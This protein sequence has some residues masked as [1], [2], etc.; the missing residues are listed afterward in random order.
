L[1]FRSGVNW[2]R[3]KE[4]SMSDL[5]WWKEACAV[6]VLSAATAIV[7]DGQTFMT[8]TNFEGRDGYSPIGSLVQGPDGNFYG[9][10]Q[11]GGHNSNGCPNIGCGTAFRV[12]AGGVVTSLAFN[13]ADGLYPS[14][15]LVLATNGNFYG[16]APQGGADSPNC[17]GD[18]SCGSLFEVTPSGRITVLHDFCSEPGCTDGG[19]PGGQYGGEVSAPLTQVLGGNF[20]GTT[21]NYG[22]NGGGTVFTVTTSGTL[23]TLYSFC[24]LSNCA[25][26]SIPQGPPIQS[27]DGI[28]YG[29]TGSG[30]NP[31][32]GD[33]GCGTFYKITPDGNLTTLHRFDGTDGW[34]IGGLIQGPNG[35]FYGT[36]FVGGDLTCDPPYGCGTVFEVT[37]AGKVT[38]LHAFEAT[39]GVGPSGQLVLGSDGNFYGTTSGS[40]NGR[41]FSYGTIFQISPQGA[42]TTLYTFKGGTDGF[43]PFGGLLQATDGK[44]YGTTNAGGGSP[45]F[46]RG[47]GTVFT[48]DLGLGPFVSF[49]FAAGKV[50]QTGGVLGQGFTGTTGVSLNGTPASFTVRSDTFLEVTVPVG[51]TTGYVTVTTPSGTL[52]S[53]VPFHVIK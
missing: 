14:S 34:D 3:R 22:A 25:D 26:G 46:G 15:G 2:S 28:L 41:Q 36:T 11:L 31:K 32:C 5:S 48:L 17:N 9:T 29:T 42:L 44:F 47:C 20:Y 12:T 40:K 33:L 35:D 8:L 1:A 23:T 16:T 4:V 30:G 49:V 39:D 51:A 19:Q 6:L 50:G 21:G 7:A 43:D 38:T 53:N 13:P 10:T 37:P 52:T 24:A 45:C 27:T 18:S